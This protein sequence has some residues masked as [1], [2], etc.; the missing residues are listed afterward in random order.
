MS[1]ISRR[2]PTRSLPSP[3]T[4][5]LDAIAGLRS[6]VGEVTIAADAVHAGFT[7][8]SAASAMN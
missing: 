7:P 4:E 2:M 8:E 6:I 3:P 1:N 5:L